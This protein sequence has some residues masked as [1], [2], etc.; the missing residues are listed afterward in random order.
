MTR[1]QYDTHW[2]D[3]YAVLQV[4]AKAEQPVISAAFRK[5]AQLYH[6]DRNKNADATD[7]FKEINEAHEVLSNPARRSTYDAASRT[8]HNRREPTAKAG[9]HETAGSQRDVRR[10]TAS[11]TY[12]KAQRVENADQPDKESGS[13]SKGFLADLA[14]TI[15]PNPDESQ[16]ILP[17]PSWAW[18]RFSLIGAVPLGLLVFLVSIGGVA[19]GG[20]VFGLLLLT[21]ALYA[22]FTT[23]WLRRSHEAPAAARITGSA[24]VLVSGITYAAAG[25]AIVLYVRFLIFG[26]KIAGSMLADWWERQMK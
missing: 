7:R 8:R 1:E 12:E 13:S 15:S 23:D 6:P 25:V 20:L 4:H 16:R 11:S 22:G 5:L 10:P 3:Y 2:K 24:C 26:V 21:G 9:H 14:N 17:W 19:W 18:Q